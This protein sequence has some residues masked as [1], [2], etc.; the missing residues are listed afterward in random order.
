MSYLWRF[1]VKKHAK[2]RLVVLCESAEH[3]RTTPFI[4]QLYP[5]LCEAFEVKTVPRRWLNLLPIRFAAG[6]LVLSLLR[7]RSW[8]SMLPKL[9]RATERSGIVF[10]D[11]DPWE[12]YHE[13]A[14]SP[15]IYPLV[16]KS[17]TVKKFLVTS[18]W[19][20]NYMRER[21]ALP[22]GFV[23]MGVL[24]EMC[25]VGPA[26]DQR[27][28]E[29]GFQGKL[30]THRKSFFERMNALGVD[31]VF[32]PSK[33]YNEFLRALHNIRIYLHDERTG[34]RLDDG[35]LLGEWLWIKESEPVARGCF[36]IRDYEDES[37]AY[38]MDQ[39]PTVMPFRSESEVP[40]IIE[41]I[42]MMP[43]REREERRRSSV[44]MLRRRN[45]WQTVVRALKEIG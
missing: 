18:Q 14:S 11:Q 32:K 39:L 20:A 13:H 25:E 27:S 41:T 42:R 37:R 24:P 44:E 16:N 5:I 28:V 45:D 9:A 33:P 38:D 3:L 19:W 35:K 36:A 23:R 4:S 22:M 40:S 17:L 29:V 10:Y 26:Y 12:A 43:E 8:K 7:Q 1:S 15:G 21:D 6:E 30:H 31:V 2:Q 34:I